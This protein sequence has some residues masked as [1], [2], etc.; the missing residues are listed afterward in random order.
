MLYSV[1]KVTYILKDVWAIAGLAIHQHGNTVFSQ[2]YEN[3]SS[4]RACMEP[5]KV[6]KVI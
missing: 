6:R 1:K 5:F 2:R 4:Y 3:G